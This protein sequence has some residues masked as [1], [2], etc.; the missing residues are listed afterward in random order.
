MFHLWVMAVWMELDIPSEIF[1]NI[2]IEIL[3]SSK[4]HRF[5]YRL[6]QFHLLPEKKKTIIQNSSID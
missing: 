1:D 2:S 3:Q 5:E 6:A 4:D